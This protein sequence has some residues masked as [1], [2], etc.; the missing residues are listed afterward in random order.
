M[1]FV[2]FDI[3]SKVIKKSV[4]VDQRR[5]SE[6]KNV[7]RFT[8]DR[9][10]ELKAKENE[11]HRKQNVYRDHN[12]FRIQSSHGVLIKR[13]DQFFHDFVFE[14]TDDRSSQIVFNFFETCCFRCKEKYSSSRVFHFQT[15]TISDRHLKIS[16]RTT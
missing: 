14:P 10:N 3:S 2:G 16:S 5:N 15:K 8:F 12:V 11:T 1:I 4:C 13:G 7:F 6:F 9:S